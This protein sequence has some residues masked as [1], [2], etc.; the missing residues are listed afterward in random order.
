ML[1]T[2]NCSIDP[3]GC[4]DIDDVFS[5]DNVINIYLADT[6]SVLL[7]NLSLFEY[8]K[9][10]TTSIYSPNKTYHMLPESISTNNCSLL[11]NNIRSANVC[12]IIVENNKIIHYGFFQTSIKVTKN[13]SYEEI[14]QIYKQKNDDYIVNSLNLI[15]NIEFNYNSINQDTLSHKCLKN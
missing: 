10:Q 3:P 12:Q 9:N 13:Y 6:T 1:I 8:A 7:N 11:E 14:D 15:D 5:S 2:K 4:T